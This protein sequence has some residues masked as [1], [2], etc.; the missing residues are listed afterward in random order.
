LFSSLIVHF[1]SD[2]AFVSNDPVFIDRNSSIKAKDEKHIS[3][4]NYK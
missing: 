2:K 1:G 4:K 3:P